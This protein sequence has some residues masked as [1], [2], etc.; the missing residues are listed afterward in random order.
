MSYYRENVNILQLPSPAK[1]PD[2]NIATTDTEDIYTESKMPIISFQKFDVL[3]NRLKLDRLHLTKADKN[4]KD[5][6]ALNR[7]L[8][9]S[10]DKHDEILDIDS[11]FD[12]ELQSSMIFNFISCIVSIIA[13]IFLIFLCYKHVKL[14]KILSFYLTTSNTVEAATD[15]RLTSSGSYILMY[16]FTAICLTLA[17][18]IELSNLSEI[19]N[20]HIAQVKI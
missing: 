13:F 7:T 8:N 19:V 5:T 9:N 11:L 15:I 14:H 17:I 10:M 16:L 18:A 20:V 6:R 12:D 2:L 3:V 1:L 4:G